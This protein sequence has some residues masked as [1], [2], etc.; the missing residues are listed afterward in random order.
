MP[1]KH[2]FE[3]LGTTY[4]CIYCF[5]RKSRWE[6]SEKEMARHGRKHAAT[7]KKLEEKSKAE[8]ERILSGEWVV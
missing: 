5:I 8:R 1:N 6:M 4:Q 3:E 7:R 2:G